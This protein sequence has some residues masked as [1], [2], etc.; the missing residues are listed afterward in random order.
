MNFGFGFKYIKR[1]AFPNNSMLFRDLQ[2]A[3]FANCNHNQRNIVTVIIIT[4]LAPFSRSLRRN[5]RGSYNLSVDACSFS[6]A[7]NSLD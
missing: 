5:S 6:G 1:V 4:T 3:N 2:A 7:G